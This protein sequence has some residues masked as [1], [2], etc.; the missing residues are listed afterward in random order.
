MVDAWP[1]VSK[2]SFCKSPKSRMHKSINSNVKLTNLFVRIDWANARVRTNGKWKREK[3]AQ[4]HTEMVFWNFIYINCGWCACAVVVCKKCIRI[5]SFAK[6]HQYIGVGCSCGRRPLW[7]RRRQQ[8]QRHH[9]NCNDTA[10]KAPR[11]KSVKT[12][13]FCGVREQRI[14]ILF[15]YSLISV[16]SRQH[17]LQAEKEFYCNF[18]VFAVAIISTNFVAMFCLNWFRARFGASGL[19]TGSMARSHHSFRAHTWNC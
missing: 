2:R 6:F 5:H 16:R 17:T 8:Q 18:C 15:Y 12:K 7:W 10:W 4:Q 11:N 14:I 13:A 9:R 19:S 1:L 3:K